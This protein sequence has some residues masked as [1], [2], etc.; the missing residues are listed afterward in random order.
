V[1]AGV[2]LDHRGVHDDCVADPRLALTHVLNQAVQGSRELRA[3][4]FELFRTAA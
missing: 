1:R 2:G 3:D 4:V